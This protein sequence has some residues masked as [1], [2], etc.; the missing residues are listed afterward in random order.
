[1]EKRDY[2]KTPQYKRENEEAS[3]KLCS[4]APVFAFD[5]YV[6]C[7]ECCHNFLDFSQFGNTYFAFGN[8]N[9]NLYLKVKKKLA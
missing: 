9:Q 5:F 3:S 7:H 8:W 4:F 1:L 2:F 6:L